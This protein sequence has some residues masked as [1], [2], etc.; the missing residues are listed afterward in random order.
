MRTWT[1]SASIGT[2]GTQRTL[3][4][5]GL[6]PDGEFSSDVSGGVCVKAPA[7]VV[8]SAVMDA[9]SCRAGVPVSMTVVTDDT[10]SKLRVYNLYGL[11]MGTLSQSYVKEDGQ[12]IWTVTMKIGTPG[13][14]T[15]LVSGVNRYGDVSD[16]VETDSI[17][18]TYF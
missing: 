4:V 13:V 10:V 17:T 18:V 5:G 1:L 14:R 3:T 15:F 2:A 7:P 11:K 16:S 6:G 8:V 12:R 9:D